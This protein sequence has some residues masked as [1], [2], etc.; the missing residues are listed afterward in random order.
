MIASQSQIKAPGVVAASGRQPT[1]M[2]INVGS[3]SN[4]VHGRLNLLLKKTATCQ[5]LNSISKLTSLPLFTS[6]GRVFPSQ[7]RSTLSASRQSVS[8]SQVRK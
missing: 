1:Q 7:R 6:S 5:L 2:K 8:R 4:G 3:K